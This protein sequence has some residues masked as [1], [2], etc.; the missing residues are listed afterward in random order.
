MAQFAGGALAAAAAVG[1]FP[2]RRSSTLEL[3]SSE[4]A[5]P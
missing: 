1:L 3:V 4:E 2:V 5:M